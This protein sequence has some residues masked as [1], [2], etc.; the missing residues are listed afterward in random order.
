MFVM[1][2]QGQEKPDE[3]K[4]SIIFNGTDRNGKLELAL[5]LLIT[6]A[7]ESP[8]KYVIYLPQLGDKAAVE[9]AM[10]KLV[11]QPSFK[12]PGSREVRVGNSTL[13]LTSFG[14]RQRFVTQSVQGILVYAIEVLRDKLQE[15]VDLK[16][17][18]LTPTGTFIGVTW[19]DNRDDAWFAALDAKIHTVHEKDEEK[20]RR[21]VDLIGNDYTQK[22]T[23]RPDGSP[24]QRV[25][26]R[27]QIF[28]ANEL[29]R[30]SDK[31]W[32]HYA[33]KQIHKFATK[34]NDQLP[35]SAEM[36]GYLIGK[37][38]VSPH[39]AERVGK[40]WDR[41]LANPSTRLRQEK[42]SKYYQESL[43][44]A[45]LGKPQPDPEKYKED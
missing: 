17:F 39:Y 24:W 7:T 42:G 6:T 11:N 14:S 30:D 28:N 27:M 41:I 15:L 33:L 32:V 4:K 16:R 37:R 5:A 31:A 45:Y 3:S 18:T 25:L 20:H 38:I 22:P 44:C 23:D 34:A 26:S 1:S 35:T 13:I 19:V 12:F 2:A 43:K 10:G 9:F 29:S 8:G 36:V 21:E 40:I